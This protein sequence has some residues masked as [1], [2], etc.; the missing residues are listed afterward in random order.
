MAD[1]NRIRWL[2]ARADEA[3]PAA[4][5]EEHDG[6]LLRWAEGPWNRTNSVATP[7]AGSTPLPAKI[8]HAERWYR[9]RERRP[10]FKLTA[11]TEPPK[12]DD[13]L[14]RCGYDVSFTVSVQAR[15][16]TAATESEVVVDERPTTAWLSAKQRIAGGSSDRALHLPTLLSRISAPA[17]FARIDEAGTTLGLGMAVITGGHAGIFDLITDPEARGRGIA[18]KIVAALEGWG[19]ARGAGTSYLQV[20]TTN[21]VALRMYERLGYRELYRYWYRELSS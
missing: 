18:G 3:W 13:V 6:W 5:V 1:L 11:A 9:N 14:R 12:L 16:I 2:E 15:D 17:G 21:E 7:D 10:V 20:E 4:I 8:D 19:A